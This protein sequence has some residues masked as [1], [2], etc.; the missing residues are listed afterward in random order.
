VFKKRENIGK[1]WKINIVYVQG[2]N[3]GKIGE[4]LSKKTIEKEGECCWSFHGR[5]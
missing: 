1:K 3:Y 5:Y 2:E 4:K